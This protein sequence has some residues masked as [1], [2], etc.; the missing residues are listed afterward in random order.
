VTT[1]SSRAPDTSAT[2]EI[3]A[4]I[5]HQPIHSTPPANSREW[6]AA[7]FEK[8]VRTRGRTGDEKLLA[9]FDVLDDVINRADREA[10]SFL[11]ALAAPGGG[12]TGQHDIDLMLQLR[13]LVSTLTDEAEI[14][15][16]PSFAL[17]W[18]VLMQGSIATAANGDLGAARSARSM[19]EVLIAVHHPA[20]LDRAEAF[21]W[22][23]VD[24]ALEDILDEYAVN[25]PAPGG[26]AA[27]EAGNTPL[28]TED[29][30]RLAR[31]DG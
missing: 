2:G 7:K 23:G 11:E 12:N 22:A 16:R 21:D 18:R 27:T 17:A 15:D 13:A 14:V 26:S 10:R 24:F 1:R 29:D 9:V 30:Y 19:A 20:V 3:S 8:S 4:A 28:L 25:I 31:S 5:S 6:T